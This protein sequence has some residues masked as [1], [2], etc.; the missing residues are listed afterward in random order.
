MKKKADWKDDKTFV[1]LANDWLITHHP[2]LRLPKDI[3]IDAVYNFAVFLDTLYK[4]M[5]YK[6]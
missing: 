4:L 6:S 5:N 3:V 1:E 2:K